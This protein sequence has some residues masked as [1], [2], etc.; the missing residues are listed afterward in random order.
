[1]Q[2]LL[3][4]KLSSLGDIVHALPVAGALRRHFSQLHITWAVE[5]RHAALVGA[6]ARQCSTEQPALASR[7]PSCKLID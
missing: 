1:M 6:R 3:I 2:R 4:V 5:A 7:Q